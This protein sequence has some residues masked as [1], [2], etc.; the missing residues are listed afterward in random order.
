ML[1]VFAARFVAAAF[2]AADSGA[3]FAVQ[4]SNSYGKVTSSPAMLTVM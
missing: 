4:V 3:S 1:P 2:A